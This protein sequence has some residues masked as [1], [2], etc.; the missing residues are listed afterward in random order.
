MLRSAAFSE[1]VTAPLTG[2][3]DARNPAD[4]IQFGDFRLVKNFMMSNDRKLCR[5]G[6]WRRLFDDDTGTYNNQDLHN[7]LVSQLYYKESYSSILNSGGAWTGLY[8]DPPYIPDE[9]VPEQNLVDRRAVPDCGYSLNFGY[10]TSPTPESYFVDS[11]FWGSPYQ[12]YDLGD[13]APCGED[14]DGYW[15]SYTYIAYWDV[16]PAYTIPGHYDGTATPVYYPSLNYTYEYCGDYLWQQQGCREA[17]THLVEFASG[18]ASRRLIAATRSRI[19]EYSR[20]IHNWRIIADGLGGVVNM[21]TECETCDDL[22]FQS[23]QLGPYIMFVNNYDQP[24]LYFADDDVAGCSLWAARYLEDLQTL[25]INKAGAIVQWKSFMILGDVTIDQQ[26]YGGRIVWSAYEDPTTWVQ[27]DANLA[28]F[29]D[30]TINETILRMIPLSDYLYVFT[31]RSIWRVTLISPE[32]GLFQFTQLYFGPKILKYPNAIQ[33]V[34]DV[35]VYLGEDD[36]Y[37]LTAYDKVPQIVPWINPSSAV[38]FEGMAEDDA[39]FGPINA[40]ACVQPVMGFDAIR[41]HLWVSWP[42]DSSVC[43]N[44]S[45]I[46]NPKENHCGYVDHGFTAFCFFN[47]DGRLTLA[48][49]LNRQGVCAIADLV[50]GEI[51]TG[52][53]VIGE[54]P[55]EGTPTPYYI[56]NEDEDPDTERSPYSICYQLQDYR[57]D[58]DCRDC[59]TDTK[60][61]M[62]DASDLTLKEFDQDS[63]YREQFTGYQFGH[64]PTYCSDHAFDG[65]SYMCVGYDSVLQSGA[66]DFK[67]WREKLINQIKVEF[68]ASPQ[69][70]PNDLYCF[71]GYGAQADCFRWR[72]LTTQELR[73]LTDNTEAQDDAGN[74]RPYDIANFPTHY[75]GRYIGWRIKVTGT[76]GASCFSRVSQ[77]VILV[78]GK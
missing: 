24:L 8:S 51:K 69:T 58:P 13:G 66:E 18:Q 19:Y 73:C 33:S 31:D 78:Q 40:N 54:L 1:V 50:E 7:Q 2:H 62:A 57:L 17:I 47:P 38:I 9:N 11:Y 42:S 67:E 15:Y 64:T 4:Q 35:I 63:Y 56:W 25:G 22:R 75:R 59:D 6:G 32:D 37:S 55:P 52:P 74:T 39:A 12:S 61:V 44:R 30:I 53:P 28:G 70:T 27:T 71:V 65:A 23:A 77:R 34:G 5:L 72:Q 43:N 45:M 26:R 3:F 76:G 20:P 16:Y 21:D 29:A 60:F 68:Q 36:I 46:L 14:G 48:E 10:P 49:W 41:N